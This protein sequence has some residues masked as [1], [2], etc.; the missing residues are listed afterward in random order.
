MSDM[1]V[2]RLAAAA[3]V[4][5]LIAY[6]L[7]AGADF[8]GGVWD[9]FASGPRKD[10][11]RAAIAHAMGPV[12]EANHVWLIFLLVLLFTCFPKAY[13]ALATNLLIPFHLALLG[14]MLRGAA[15]VFRAYA[16][17]GHSRHFLLRNPA[18]WEDV[19]G[20][21]SIISPLM[22]GASFGTVTASPTDVGPMPT[23]LSP[24]P[25]ICGVLALSTCAYLAAVYLC[26]ETA[27]QLQED[28]R[29]RAIIAGTTTA[30]L[31]I[32]TLYMAY[33]HARWFFDRML[34]GRTVP[35]LAAGLVFF[36]ASAYA[37]F[38]RRYRLAQW[39]AAGEIT[40]LLIG[41]ALAQSPYIAY[42]DHT[43]QSS[44]APV[45]TIKFLLMSLI[46]GLAVLLPS[47]V[48]LFRVFKGNLKSQI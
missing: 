8:G 17:P 24:Y 26:R 2:I 42:P 11:Q 13:A 28:F 27:G 39:C 22:L 1:L 34:E 35:V 37:V 7:L 16:E 41:W 12:W 3:A 5:A 23:W 33:F 38:N 4:F 15:F 25:V 29:R 21:T 32:I 48:L 43:L 6:A 18:M 45:A 40:L 19:F 44:A 31:S 30:A 10:Q 9:L 47:L 14:I 36:A 20:V 46:P